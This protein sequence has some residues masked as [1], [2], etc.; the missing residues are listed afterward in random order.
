MKKY[1]F[2]AAAAT[3]AACTQDTLIDDTKVPDTKE[4]A[5]GFGTGM[6]NITRAEAEN[7]SATKKNDLSIYHNSF[8][9]WGNKAVG[10]TSPTYTA[11]FVM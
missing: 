8:Y 7:S 3:L 2:I 10:S 6:N 1:L 11:V 9:V 5:I 4:V